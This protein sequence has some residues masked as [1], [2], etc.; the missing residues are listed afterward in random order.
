MKP[1]QSQNSALIIVDMQ[2]EESLEGGLPVKGWN[3]VVK[4]AKKVLAA[5]RKEN[6]PVVYVRIA[7][8]PDGID[9]HDF[10][11]RGENGVPSHSVEGTKAAQV[12]EELRPNPNDIIITK[13]RWSAFFQTNM[14]LILRGLKVKH[15]I[16]MGVYT[17]SCFLTSVYDA[18]FRGY[19]ISIIKDACGAGTD[20]AHKTSILDMANW[21]YGCSIFNADEMVKALQGKDYSAWF[22]EKHNSVPYSLETVEELYKKLE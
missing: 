13:Q 20:A 10:D 5:C 6:V 18:F 8:R 16:M 21:I 3:N 9:A 19:R 7:R 14:E 11:V 17:D 4:N 12:I 15:L 1:F 2:Y 22:W